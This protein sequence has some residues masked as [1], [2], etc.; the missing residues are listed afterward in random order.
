MLSFEIIKDGNAIQIDCDQ[1]GLKTLINIL[2][3]LKDNATH[4]HMRRGRELSEHNPWG[5]EGVSEVIIT[6]GGD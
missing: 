2:E 3:K 1:E 6:T 5:R 4:V